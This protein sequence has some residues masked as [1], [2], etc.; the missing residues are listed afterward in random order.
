[1]MRPVLLH[2]KIARLVLGLSLT[3]LASSLTHAQEKDSVD[4]IKFNT[5][6]VVFDAQVIDKKTRRIMGELTKS[7]FEVSDG[8]V[9]QE[10]SYF[11]RDELPLSVMLLLSSA[12]KCVNVSLVDPVVRPS[13][14]IALACASMPVFVS[15][16]IVP[17]AC[18]A[19]AAA[20]TAAVC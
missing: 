13:T 19:C 4:V 5:D 12:M 20:L 3:L 1:M 2:H 16:V 11:S 7:D 17:S 18:E 9:R 6:L 8:G 10:I 15:S 14:R